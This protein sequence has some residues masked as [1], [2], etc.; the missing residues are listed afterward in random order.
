[1]KEEQEKIT[2]LTKKDLV[3][4]WFSGGP[5]SGGQHRNKHDNC[6]RIFHPESGARAQS[7]SERSQQSNLHEA[8]QRLIRTPQMKFW[9]SRRLREIETGKTIEQEVEESMKPENLKIEILVDGKWQVA[10]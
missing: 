4:S 10:Q 2:L 8:F 5:G 6:C 1:M 7:T 9:I 3:I